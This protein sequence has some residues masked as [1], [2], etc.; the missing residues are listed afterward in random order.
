MVLHL[1]KLCV[2]VESADDLRARTEQRQILALAAGTSDVQV[3]T[4]RMVPKRRDEILDGGSLYWVIKGAIQVRQRILD[5][6]EY[7]DGGGRKACDLILAPQIVSVEMQPK[8]P[9][10][11]WRYLKANEAPADIPDVGH[12]P[13][14]GAMPEGMQRELK[15]LC[16]I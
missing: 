6:R 13:L 10:Q 8:R 3:H 11:G 9:F 2:G 5:I 1:V 4:T 15:E 14:E 12:V 7:K 16:L